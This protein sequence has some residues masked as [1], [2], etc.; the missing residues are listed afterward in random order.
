M[1]LQDGLAGG[2]LFDARDIGTTCEEKPA[3]LMNVGLG[4]VSSSGALVEAGLLPQG[5]WWSNG[6]GLV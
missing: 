2:G 6:F 3:S 1:F 5:G 4:D